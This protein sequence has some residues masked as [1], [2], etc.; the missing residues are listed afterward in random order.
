MR[1]QRAHTFH[2]F[3]L[4]TPPTLEELED[5]GWIYLKPVA[6]SGEAIS[7]LTY[8]NDSSTTE[9]EDDAM[10]ERSQKLEEH[11][12]S[13]LKS[14]TEKTPGQIKM[15]KA[16]AEKAK[17][18]SSN[19]PF[20]IKEADAWITLN[21]KDKE[22]EKVHA[23]MDAWAHCEEFHLTDMRDEIRR[24]LALLPAASG[25]SRALASM[26]DTGIIIPSGLGVSKNTVD[27]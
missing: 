20:S 1:E 22:D 5:F 15:A 13:L 12:A 24:Y 16:K 27:K 23:I 9:I 10:K 17:E 26:K 2:Q 11:L 18:R 21:F 6:R 14:S 3:I 8:L 25:W 7:S 4:S 19:R